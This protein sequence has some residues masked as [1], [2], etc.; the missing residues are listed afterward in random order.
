MLNTNV[1]RKTKRRKKIAFFFSG[2][3]YVTFLLLFFSI[4]SRQASDAFFVRS[5]FQNANFPIFLED[6]HNE[7]Q[8]DSLQFLVR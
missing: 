8:H 6:F 5:R 7:Q 4:Q 3:F 2:I 1:R